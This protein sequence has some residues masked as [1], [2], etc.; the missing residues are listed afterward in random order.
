MSSAMIYP[1][2]S[3]F[4]QK[5]EVSQML[6]VFARPALV[7]Q[8]SWP[9]MILNIKSGPVFFVFFSFLSFCKFEVGG[10]IDK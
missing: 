1:A 6:I 7:V 8:L 3:F 5:R 4:I 2:T 9:L 10:E